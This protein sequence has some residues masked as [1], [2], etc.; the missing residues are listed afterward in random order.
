MSNG[1]I[2]KHKIAKKQADKGIL[3]AKAL[4]GDSSWAIKKL[5]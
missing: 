2:V 4:K 1:F 5:H 3:L